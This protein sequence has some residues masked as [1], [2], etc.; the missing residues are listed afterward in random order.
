AA[1]RT[2]A[3]NGRLYP[4]P[5]TDLVNIDFNNTAA[6]NNISVEVYDLSGR[7]NYRKVFGKLPVGNNTIKV[8]AKDASMGT[9]V[10]I[11]TLSA[12]GK[13]LQANKV[14]RTSK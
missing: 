7:L 6:D 3:V 8:G 9:G 11:I 13:A 5:F 4:N 12:N 1:E 14:I 2:A 10:Y